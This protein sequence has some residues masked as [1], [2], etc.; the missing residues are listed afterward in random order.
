MK[1]Y[2]NYSLRNHNTFGIDARSRSF[3]EYDTPEE[4][5]D[6]LLAPPAGPLLHIGGGSNLLFLGDFPGTVLHS[7][8]RG[9]GAEEDKTTVR[10]RVGA[11]MQWDD[12]VDYTLSRGWY[13]LENLSLIPGEAGASAVQNIGAYGSEAKDC[14]ASVECMDLRSGQRRTFLNEECRYGYR[15]SLFKQ[16]EHRGRWAVLYVTYRL[17]KTFSP[18]LGYGGI[19]AELENRGLAAETLTAQQLRQ[20]IIDIRR[21]KL[22]DPRQ[23]GNAGSFFMNPVVPREQYEAL[24]TRYPQMP[25][26]DVDAC[27]VKIP[28]GWMIDRC[29]WKGRSLGRAGVHDRQALVLVNLGNASGQ[30]V[31]HLC[32]V[33]RND[34]REKF[35]IDIHPEVNF[36]PASGKQ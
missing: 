20:V 30:D 34:V 33:I 5:H 31:L 19:R 29:G 28:A 25:H 26:Y 4:L 18:R 8:I 16:E 7:G 17:S 24:L 15:Q 14:I 10:V 11:A 36:I 21:A 22:P 2:E 13:G 6:F 23:Q 9:I 3:V 27:H 12:V 1:I 35:G 32:E